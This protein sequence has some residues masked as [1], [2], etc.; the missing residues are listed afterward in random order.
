MVT[1]KHTVG[2]PL[3]IHARP[4][5]LLA[6]E[7]GRYPC[8]V[9]VEKDGN[10]ADARQP[11]QVLGL[12]ARCGDTLTVRCDGAREAEAAGAVKRFLKNNL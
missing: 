12:L 5:V 1:F 9:F 3:G 2:D 6:R 11:A 8:A 10:A 4:A 7:A